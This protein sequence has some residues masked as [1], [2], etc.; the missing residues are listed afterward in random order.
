MGDSGRPH[1]TATMCPMSDPSPSDH[2]H[3]L[4]LLL[5]M[6][7]ELAQTTD[8]AETGDLIARH[9]A[10]ATGAEECAVSYWDRPADAVITYGYYPPERRSAL[11][12]S[13]QLD[14]YPET[15]RVLGTQ[16]HAIIDIDDPTADA[17][18]VEYLRSIGN[19]VSAMLPLVAKRETIGLVE[20]ASA[21]RV[22]FDE[23]L[24]ALARSMANEAAMALENARLYEALRRQ[25]LHDPLTGLANRTLFRDR[26]AHALERSIRDGSTVGVLFLD[27]DDFKTVNDGLG[28]LAGDRL[29]THVAERLSRAI[30]PGDTVARLGGDEFGILLERTPGVAEAMA[31]ANRLLSSLEPPIELEGRPCVP[32]GSIGI[33]LGSAATHDV[34][35][36]LANADFAMYQAKSLGKGRCQLFEPEMRHV[37]VRRAELLTQLRGALERDEFFV[38]YQPIVELSTGRIEGLEALVRWRH[39]QRGLVMPGEF[40]SL[41]EE[42]GLIVPIGRLV[43][44]QACEHVASWQVTHGRP[45]LRLHVNVSPRQVKDATLV[46]DV[47]EAL[48]VS[49][50][51][52]ASLT[53]EITEN[54]RLGDVDDALLR[55]KELKTLGISLAVDDFGT[56]YSSLSYL[57]RFPIDVLKIDRSFVER[58]GREDDAEAL[59]RSILEIARTLRLSTVAEGVERADQSAVLAQLHCEFGQGYLLE[60]PRPADE[61]DAMLEAAISA[62]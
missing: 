17:H 7:S 3:E 48:R 44:R 33:S 1:Q 54:L 25:A 51:T 18:E 62:A 61:I 45:D 28:H 11:E 57:Q 59:V 10:L 14:E 29:L 34:D 39:P 4:Q 52:P 42:T 27:L 31:I 22:V 19:T 58:L 21:K 53:L 9:I 49:G 23:T 6:S 30:R 12:L 46:D 32:R 43:L 60:V 38:A 2:R 56:G 26:A 24:L 50:L 35:T 55:L 8:P 20:L 16:Q 36:L 37:A 5:A 47:S 15:R 41:A 40:I 13:Y